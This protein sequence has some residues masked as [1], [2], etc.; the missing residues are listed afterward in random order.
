MSV[1]ESAF[2]VENKSKLVII[3]AFLGLLAAVG[4]AAGIGVTRSLDSEEVSSPENHTAATIPSTTPT[5]IISPSAA[6]V[7]TPAG[8]LGSVGDQDMSET[9]DMTPDPTK[10][11]ESNETPAPVSTPSLEATRPSISSEIDEA[12]RESESPLDPPSD[13]IPTPTPTPSPT[14]APTKTPR[15]TWPEPDPDWQEALRQARF[16]TRLWET[17][18]SLHSVLY[19]EILQGGPPRDGIPP[20]DEPVFASIERMDESIIGINDQEPVIAFELNGDARAYPIQILMWHEIVNDMVGGVPVTVTF[21]PLCNAAI[22]FDRRLDGVVYDFGTTGNLRKSDLIMW[23]R[24]TESWWQQFTGEAI[25]GELTGKVLTFLPA[26]M[27]SWA[28]FKAAYPTGQVLWFDTG[29]ERDYGSNPYSGYD[30][31]DDPPF[32][33]DGD[34]DGRLLPKERVV[35]VTIGDDAAAFPFSILEKERVVNYNLSGQD[36]VVFWVPGTLSALDEY[37]IQYSRDVGATGVFDPNLDDR[38]LTFRVEGDNIVDNETDSA[39]NILG[40][41]IGGPLS[42]S[43]LKPIIHA[44]HFWFSW[45][46]F[47]PDTKIYQGAD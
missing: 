44:D 32:L 33:F 10:T 7:P 1:G 8:A 16:S 6:S 43:K 27:V 5:Q 37:V 42:G 26:S 47:K 19:S 2:P 13:D 30:R 17:D 40:Q 36:L 45:A 21:C 18:F 22:V 3:L 38:R 12:D 41:A 28:D 20:I 34:L 25:V 24:Q 46:A 11:H 23:D 14:P 35:A 15:L 4:T 29:F 31:A 9:E 39:W